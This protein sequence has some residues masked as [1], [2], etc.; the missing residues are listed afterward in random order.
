MTGV[1]TCALPISLLF[2]LALLLITPVQSAFAQS[3]NVAIP[4]P[5]E[6]FGF[7]IGDDYQLANF[8]QTE[9]YLKKLAASPRVKLTSIG[10]TEEGRNQYMMIVSS[11]ENL[12]NL[13]R[14]KEIAQRM[15]RAEDLTDEQARALADEGKAVVWIDGGLHSTETVGMQQLIETAWQLVSRNDAETRRILE[16]RKSTRLNSSHSTLSRMPSSA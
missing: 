7:A 14:Y 4:S 5:K 16:D 13:T 3:G 10:I 11:P 8:T 9:A 1:Q 15:A 2:L 12:K 6:Q